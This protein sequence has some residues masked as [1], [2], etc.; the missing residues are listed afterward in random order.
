MITTTLECLFAT[1]VEPSDASGTHDGTQS[2]PNPSVQAET[3][4]APAANAGLR[5]SAA[6]PS[7][8]SL[9]GSPRKAPTSSSKTPKPRMSVSKK[10][11]LERDGT[12]LTPRS[13][14][15]YTRFIKNAVH[16]DD[17]YDSEGELLL[18]SLPEDEEEEE[19]EILVRKA[20]PPQA[21][22]EE[23]PTEK[24]VETVPNAP[25]EI[26]HEKLR[27]MTRHVLQEEL[28]IRDCTLRGPVEEV[29]PL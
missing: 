6:T 26:S 2:T 7:S 17:G 10:L 23:Q 16:F 13:T 3:A 29:R 19:E 25:V 8:P 22:N 18:P 12:L 11:E 9:M 14:K 24:E 27:K 5:T 21:T 28:Y 1:M 20:S 15:L 4:L